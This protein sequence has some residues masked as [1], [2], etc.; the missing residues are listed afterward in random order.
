MHRPTGIEVAVSGM[1]TLA[2]AQGIG[3]FAFTPM[4]PIMQSEAGL[5]LT[6]GSWLAS[7]NYIGYLAGALSAIWLRAKAGT[8]V[9]WSLLAIAAL[10]AA[11]ATT[12][13]QTAWLL[14]RG[15]A[16]LVSAWAMVFA[17]AWT[18][19]ALAELNAGRLAGIVFGGVGLGIA[20]AGM[21]CIVFL[22][23]A[24]SLAEDWVALGAVA[25]ALTAICWRTYGGVTGAPESATRPAPG[26]PAR[27]RTRSSSR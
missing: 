2:V 24:F 1:L 23:F 19:H 12:H 11:M 22:R 21:L 4:L 3:R 16:G 27:W 7:A 8:V 5:T 25:L 26:R 10:T 6:A 15:G 13:D 14:L 20:L 17:S 18:M 9:R